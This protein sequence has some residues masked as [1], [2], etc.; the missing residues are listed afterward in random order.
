MQYES[1]SQSLKAAYEKAI[2][3]P[4]SESTVY[5]VLKRHDWRKLVPRPFH[6]DRDIEAQ[7]EY[8]KRL[9]TRGKEGQTIAAKRGRRLRIMFADEARFGRMNRPRPCWA[10]PGVRPAVASQILC[11]GATGGNA[12]LSRL[13]NPTA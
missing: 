2:G 7:N 13:A 3:H 9:C 6:P 4:T 5:N 1:S 10:P 8:K 12:L 11:S